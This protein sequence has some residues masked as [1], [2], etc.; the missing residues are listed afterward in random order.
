MKFLNTPNYSIV[1]EAVEIAKKINISP[2]FVNAVLRKI[3][4]KDL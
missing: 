4:N 3:I 2:S 1:N